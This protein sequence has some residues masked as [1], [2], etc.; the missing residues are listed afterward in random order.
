MTVFDTI[1][2]SKTILPRLSA[3]NLGVMWSKAYL[4]FLSFLHAF[5]RA[6]S[7]LTLFLEPF[8]FL[9]KDF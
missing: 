1:R 7:A 8:F 2:F 5:S 3:K 4:L 9:D 6:T